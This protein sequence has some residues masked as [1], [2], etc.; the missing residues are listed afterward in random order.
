VHQALHAG[1]DRGIDVSIIDAGK[2]GATPVVIDGLKK[3]R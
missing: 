2:N 1:A 3:L